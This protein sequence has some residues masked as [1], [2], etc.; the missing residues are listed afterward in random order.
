MCLAGILVSNDLLPSGAD[1]DSGANN[2][3]SAGQCKLFSL[4]NPLLAAARSIV[5][6][7]RL[8]LRRGIGPPNSQWFIIWN[9]QVPMR[10]M[11]ALMSR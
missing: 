5:F 10:I 6:T 3:R 11:I 7:W 9:R 2:R 8:R 1:N 4:L